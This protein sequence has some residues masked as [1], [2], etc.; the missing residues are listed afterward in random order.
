[1]FE[2]YKTIYADLARPKIHSTP[3]DAS[4]VSEEDEI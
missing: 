3:V 2:K 4:T 1:V